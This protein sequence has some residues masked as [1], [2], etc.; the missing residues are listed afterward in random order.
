MNEKYS[1]NNFK[2]SWNEI[3]FTN[4]PLWIRFYGA[5]IYEFFYCISNGG[6][7][8]GRYIEEAIVCY[9]SDSYLLYNKNALS[10]YSV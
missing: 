7:L 1:E 4:I 10:L 3:G 9:I 2:G 6:N 5:S 8:F